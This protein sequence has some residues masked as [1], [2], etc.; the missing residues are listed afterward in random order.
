MAYG[1]AVSRLV[2]KVALQF[3]AWGSER[4]GAEIPEVFQE[5]RWAQDEPHYDLECS[6]IHCEWRESTTDVV[7]AEELK[8][9]HEIWHE[10][11][12]QE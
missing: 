3:L 8:A 1:I 12:M 11:G 10:E 6:S 4:M 2:A 5:V 7:Y 9:S